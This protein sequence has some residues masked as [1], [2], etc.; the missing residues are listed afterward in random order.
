MADLETMDLAARV[1]QSDAFS[2][3]VGAL[4]DLLA[5]IEKLQ[6][7]HHAADEQWRTAHGALEAAHA[8]QTE[9]LE[10]WKA[11]H[12]KAD[13]L[14]RRKAA[15]E[16]LEADRALQHDELERW[17]AAHAKLE[18]D[19]H[20]ADEHWRSAHGASEAARASQTEETERWKAAHAK[21]EADHHA[22]DEHWRAAHGELEAAHASQAEELEKWKAAHDHLD[23]EGAEFKRSLEE[24]QRAHSDTEKTLDDASATR[25]RARGRAR[26][27]PRRADGL[28]A[29]VRDAGDAKAEA[30]LASRRVLELESK[31]KQ[32]EGQIASLEEERAVLST[33]KASE[34]DET[35]ARLKG[36]VVSL[37]AGGHVAT[38]TKLIQQCHDVDSSNLFKKSHVAVKKAVLKVVAKGDWDGSEKE[39]WGCDDEVLT[40]IHTSWSKDQCKLFLKD[41]EVL[42]V[43]FENMTDGERDNVPRTLAEITHNVGPLVQISR[44]CRE[45]LGAAP[46]R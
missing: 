26:G 15:N 33:V 2:H 18:A 4:R 34:N 42:V 11:A 14:E 17:K 1:G 44:I 19:H 27:G 6:T 46:P 21:L 35:M 41:M 40:R 5:H 20:A 36:E 37:R 13:E 39:E 28:A 8:S 45:K 23:A 16:Q 7:D 10:R 25:A 32:A 43:A 3:G 29:A 38:L 12:A 30:K 24:W 22:A 31:L 9:E